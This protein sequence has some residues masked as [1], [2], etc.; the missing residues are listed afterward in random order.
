QQHLQHLYSGTQPNDLPQLVTESRALAEL[1]PVHANALLG[2]LPE[3]QPGYIMVTLDGEFA[4]QVKQIKRLLHAGMSSVRI[5]CAHED[6]ETWL[7][8]IETVK[9]AKV[10]TGIDCRLFM[11]LA[12]PK[13]RTGSM[14]T[15][16]LQLNILPVTDQ[17]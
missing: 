16:P 1:L 6:P 15:E 2:P 8:I 17:N 11:D 3:G 10:E 5:N 7:K 9:Q 4:G 12:G 14:E 13:I